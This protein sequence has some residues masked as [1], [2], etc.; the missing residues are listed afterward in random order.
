MFKN[1]TLLFTTILVLCAPYASAQQETATVTGEVK[2]GSGAVV[3]KATITITN[4]GTNIS[5]RSETNELGSYTVPN[6]RPGAYNITVEKSGFNKT[7]R[8]GL[9]LQVNQV[10]RIDLALLPGGVNEVIEVTGGATLLE[11][12]TSSRGAV[13]DQKKIVDLP[14]NGRDYNQLALLSPGVLAGTPRLASINFKGA[15]N[16]NGNRVFMNVFLL[17]GVDNISY[18]NSF[19]GDNVQVVQPSIEALQEFKIQTNAYSAEFGRSAGA[20]VNAAIKSGT[21]GFHGSA[22][23][24]LR[25]DALDANNFFA[26]FTGQEK[27][28]RQRNQLGGTLGGPIIKNRTFFFGDYEG[29][30]EREGIVRIS[31]LPLP[32][33]KNG[34]FAGAV[35]D[36]FAAGRPAF[37]TDSQGRWVIPQDRWD[38]VGAQIAAL[39]PDPNLTGPSNNYVATPVTRTRQDQFDV[40]IDHNFNSNLNAFGRYSFVDSNLFRPAPLP[41]LAEGSFND[42]FGTGDSRSQGLAAGVAWTINSLMAADIRFGH[43][44][45]DYFVFPPNF[46]VNGAQ[47]VGLN[48]VPDDPQIAGGL[49][50][51]NLQ[52]FS[53]IGRHTSTPQFQTPRSYDFKG[54]LSYLRGRHFMKYGGEML[55]VKTGIRDINALIGN[56]NF[57][58]NLFTGRAIGDLLLGL[59]QRLTLTSNSVFNQKQQLYFLYLQ[60]DFKVSQKLTLNLGLRYEYATPVVEEDNQFVNLDPLTGS[61]IT[62]KDGDLF[63][64]ALVRPDR[65]NFAPRFGFAWSPTGRWVVR[66]AYGIFYNHTNRQGREGLLGFNPPFL[67][68]NTINVSGID[69]PASS[70][71]F[72]LQNG[73]P[74][75]LLD[76][77][78]LTPTIMRRAQDIDQRSAY[79]QQWNFGIQR[80]VLRDLLFEI[81]YVGN[82]GTKLAGFRNLNQRAVVIN[83]QTGRASAGARPFPQFG[84]IQFLENRVLSNYHSMQVRVEKRYSAGLTFLGSY[85]WGKALTLSP[86]HLSTSGVGAGFDVGTF[87]EPQNP[88]DLRS[89]RGLAE[90]DIEHRG[91]ISYVW[92]IPYGK[93][94]KFGK[95]AST[96]GELLFGGWNVTGIHTFQSGLGLTAIQ[97]GGLVLDLGGE[98]RGRPN[99]IGDPEGPKTTEEWFNKAAFSQINP[100]QGIVFGNSGVGVMRGPGLVNF[101]FTFAKNIAVSETKYFQFRTELFNAFN[102]TNL[103]LPSLDIANNA[104]GSIRTTATPAR[105]IQFALKFY[106]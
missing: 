34:I 27:P 54:S 105:I 26:N 50:K 60:D 89:E 3:P 82:K 45:G 56:L 76:P 85:T 69:Q 72:R 57:N 24:F 16:V 6:L 37:G 21:N 47:Q 53:A 25:N 83:P 5:I 33:E 61:V 67:V 58:N 13:I 20:V 23:E 31:T 29:L 44:R 49:P 100:N 19:R 59:P 62:A 102:H 8:S 65:N 11:T 95:N 78:N 104:F 77:G 99:L 71:I 75:G 88:N 43:T 91:V 2:D 32:S 28:V 94:R 14:L 80:E 9:V 92:E 74:S 39:I 106:F 86:D 46:G 1:I 4:T 35:F 40:R 64:R 36:P 18:S 66:G 101:D 63:D 68:D 90:F 42:A 10:V 79:I 87:R 52:G 41:G 51:I 55:L 17:D 70:A 7:V 30:R 103:G 97:T 12:E 48:N 22:Y 38:P 96:L 84:D 73:Y 98:R 93:T 15:I 81:A